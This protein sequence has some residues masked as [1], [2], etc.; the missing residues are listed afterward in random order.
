M[1]DN[2]YDNCHFFLGARLPYVVRVWG[3]TKCVQCVEPVIIR[4]VVKAVIAFLF[5]IQGAV[6]NY[7]S[8]LLNTCRNN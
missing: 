4:M 3:N 8:V 5:G 7:K 2:Q 1:W 6:R